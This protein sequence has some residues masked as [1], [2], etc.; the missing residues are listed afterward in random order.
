MALSAGVVSLSVKPDTKDFGTDLKSKLL[1]HTAGVGESMGGMLKDGLK[2]MAGPVAAVAAGMSIEHIVEGSIHSFEDLAGQVNT[3]KRV[4][5]GSVEDV[6]ALR[7]AFQLSGVDVDR[8]TT[9]MAKFEKGLVFTSTGKMGATATALED[10]GISALDA[11][12]KVRPMSELLPEVADKFKSMPDGAQKTALSMQLFGKSGTAMLPFLNKGAEGIK[13]LEDKAKSMGLTLD[14]AAIDKFKESKVAQREFQATMQGLQVTLGQAF[15]PVLEG[16]QNAFREF[17]IPLIE[18]ATAFVKSHVKE[19]DNLGSL[20]KSLVVPALNVLMAVI[21]G[22]INFFLKFHDII[23]G[24]M[25]VVGTAVAGWKLYVG[26]ME[27]VK[28]VKTL[29]TAATVAETGATEGATAAQTLMNAVLAANPIAL[30][31]I[32]VAALVA[33]LIYFFT[34]TKIGQQIW[35]DFSK[36]MVVVWNATVKAVSDAWNGVVSFFSA[37]WKNI[38]GFFSV[39]LKFILDLFLNWTIWGLIIKNWG[40]IESFFSNSLKTIG[41]FFGD[42]FNGIGKAIGSVWDGIVASAKTAFN[43]IISIIDGVI[44]TVNTLLSALKTVTGGAV[45]IK[46]PNIPKLAEGGIVPATPGGRLVRVAEAGQAEA[47]IPLNK[48]N[49]M[50]ASGGTGTT[51]NYYA[52]KNDSIS[53]EQKLVDA[54]QRARVLGWT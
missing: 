7:A 13:E 28:L 45:N 29:M 52:A 16:V 14:E 6:S 36:A 26:I 37:S 15:L 11:T 51:I 24:L 9:S 53:A 48:L 38:Q 41:K 4:M 2:S 17:F 46:I 30:V 34:Q 40:A 39:A 12:G 44:G 31:V 18:K 5:G 42:T 43:T 25:I 1:G 21:E 32:A 50:T 23:I 8:A 19:F 10:V 35:A 22:V 49:S 27:T 33:G 47:V 3:M 20:L 54:V